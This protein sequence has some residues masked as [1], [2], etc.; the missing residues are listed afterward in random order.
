MVFFAFLSYAYR[1][2]SQNLRMPA[3]TSEWIGGGSEETTWMP[4]SYTVVVYCKIGRKKK[5]YGEML[6][7]II[8][9]S[10][11]FNET[12]KKHFLLNTASKW[13]V[14][15]RATRNQ[16]VRFSAISIYDPFA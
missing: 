14:L 12:A 13:F 11:V 10:H 5:E 4:D 16:I 2:F 7:I 8:S 3:H 9:H 1:G 6:F 15:C